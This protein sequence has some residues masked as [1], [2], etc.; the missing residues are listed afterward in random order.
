M[1]KYVNGEYI[2]MT[3]EEI[4]EIEEAK[5][6]VDKEMVQI[7]KYKTLADITIDAGGVTSIR[8]SIE[9]ILKYTELQLFAEMPVTPDTESLT[10]VFFYGVAEATDYSLQV[11]LLMARNISAIP[12]EVILRARSESKLVCV[13]GVL[14]SY[15]KFTN[16]SKELFLNSTTALTSMI[17]ENKI[18]DKDY[19]FRFEL[20]TNKQIEL[21]I[22]TRIRLLARE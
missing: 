17:N 16:F 18:L 9:S 4:R 5:K 3:E 19:S 11:P 8:H 13:D 10:G 21:P 22:G 1:K 12:E 20:T 6:Q 7:E 14:T 15:T 2:E